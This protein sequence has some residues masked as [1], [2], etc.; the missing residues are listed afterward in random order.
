MGL[1]FLN[2][3]AF[4]A[5]KREVDGRYLWTPLIQHLEDTG[6]VSV[7][8][9]EHWLS[10]GQRDFI[11]DSISTKNS[12]D[13]K[14]IVKFIGMIH[15]IGKAT[16]V[17]QTMKGY[18]NSNDLD[19]L[20]LEKLERNGFN[21]ISNLILASPRASRHELAG[22][23]I[24]STFGVKNDIGSI[25]GGHHGK[26]IDDES[27]YE[28]QASYE[29]N[30][31]QYEDKEHPVRELWIS[32]QK[33]IFDYALK[34][35]GFDTVECLP[36]IEQPAQVLLLGLLIM[37]DWISSNE[38]Y[39]PL[40]DIFEDSI[41]NKETRLKKG[42]LRWIKSDM[43]YPQKNKNY[44]NLYKNRFGFE[45]RNVQDRL[46]KIVS[47]TGEPGI[48]IL[49]APMG[50]GKTEASLIAAEQLAYV[51]GRSGLFFGLPTQATSDGIFHR[52]V[53]WLNSVS[54]DCDDRMQ[55]RLA[56]GK[57]H[58]NDT[59]SSLSNGIG[60]DGD[61]NNVIVN[62]WF[63]GR[64]TTSL[65]DFVVGTVD[66]FLL[67][68]LK[69]RHLFLR[70]IGFSK[71]VIIIDEVHAYDTYMSQYLKQS[72]KWMGAYGVP[73]I[74]L[75]ATLPSE[76][77]SEL[78]LSY[79]EGRY[80]KNS[81]L[82][83]N[84]YKDRMKTN[85]YPLITYTNGCDLCIE[86]D[87]EKIED[88]NIKIESMVDDELIWKVE[89]L[90][91]EG[92]VIGIIVNTVKRGQLF[93]EKLSERFGD[94]V[95]ILLHSAFIATERVK[96]EKYLLNMIGKEADRPNK[97]VI[98]GTQVLEQSLDIDFD[99]LISDLAPV[100]LLIQRLGRL[101]RHT[102]STNTVV[103]PK[104]HKEP[105]LY[106]LGKNKSYDFEEGTASIYEKYLLMRTQYFIDKKEYIAI[107]GDISNLVQSVYGETEID[108]GGEL[109]TLYETYK[110]DMIDN[111]EYKEKK[112]RIFRIGNPQNKKKENS[113]RKDVGLIGWLQNSNID[114]KNDDSE[115]RAYAQVRDS[116]ETVEVI[117]I[118][119]NGDGYSIYGE[120]KDIS[121]NIEDINI[122]K[123]LAQNTVKLPRIYS[124]NY[125]I[126]RTI[127][128]LEQYNNQYLSAWRKVHWLKGSLG[129]ILDEKN[130][131]KL[132]DRV[133][134]YD[135]RY[136]IRMV[137]TERM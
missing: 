23:Y 101:H 21:G 51:T 100:D 99:V 76:K 102:T 87:F 37:S 57:A 41:P 24:L 65:D 46:S 132:C 85:S 88:K 98:I 39:F 137:E 14:K 31:F 123:K 8:L 84:E 34:K 30:M 70:H 54:A 28:R 75:S 48:I 89:E 83:R 79:L 68:S 19:I 118:K 4:W 78:V 64:K 7:L 71:K 126:D 117:L 40:L 27:D 18:S 61:E 67:L 133:F 47:D 59:F 49:E 81:K 110:K 108:L 3:N 50:I 44:K 113:R 103:R 122:A 120:S 63:S 35:C 22:E 116:D 25:I 16:P 45:P 90:L 15:D 80:G 121:K 69:Q 58:L 55:I 72:I 10:E 66:Q 52:I 136:G 74:L 131:F 12:I 94:E 36:K 104:S 60:I 1:I 82:I 20:L 53:S 73:I 97:K 129:I 112:A 32:S 2:T 29:A 134:K 91:K 62:Q 119:K 56:H 77:R 6:G 17:F 86:E 130:E 26:T 127:D 114:T 109:G 9:W 13:A 95:V 105:K 38:E 128:E 5:K 11:K 93:A 125:M 111:K 33:E 96:K 115:E 42:F 92:G 43:W 124:T 135:D 107:P 106:I